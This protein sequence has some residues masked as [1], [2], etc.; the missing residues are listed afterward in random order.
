M[1]SYPEC[2]SC[3][4][5]QA[6]R[7]S[8][9][10]SENPA[11]WEEVIRRL[12]GRVKEMD[13]DRDTPAAVSQHV[14]DI[15]TDVTGNADPYKSM[16]AETNR[17]AK[18]LLPTLEKLVFTSDDPLSSA[19]HMAVAGNVIDFGINPD[20]K[21][22]R[23]VLPIANQT[24]AIDDID[25]FREDIRPGAKVLYIGDN[26][27]EIIFDK[28]LVEELLELGTELTYAVKSAPIINDVTIED[29]EFAGLTDIV[30]VIGTGSG[31][32]GVNWDHASEEFKSCFSRADIII[33]KGHANFETLSE[34]E[35]NIY[36]LLKTKCVCV[37]R[38]L[39]VTLGDIV[40]KRQT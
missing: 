12:A 19:V 40:F 4:F 1:K 21:V 26:S 5:G 28:V 27:G 33:S 20:L 16:K 8:K 29:A 35:A 15:V 13:L 30:S 3:I 38:E 22:E 36:F 37:A 24:F 18:D 7:T 6:I 31:H 10:A 34:I 39:G 25:Q 11:E 23:D 32:M 9:V 2:L 14:Y 17:Q